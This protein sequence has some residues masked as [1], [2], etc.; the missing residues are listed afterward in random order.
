MRSALCQA[1]ASARARREQQR[2]AAAGHENNRM[3]GWILLE[4][5]G[6]LGY[7]TVLRVD[8]RRWRLLSVH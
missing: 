7:R 1:S 4:A 2:K 6:N 5:G 8:I 3:A